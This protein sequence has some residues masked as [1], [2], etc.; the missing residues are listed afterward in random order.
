MSDL[1]NQARDHA[2]GEQYL[3]S[4]KNGTTMSPDS[5]GGK[6]LLASYKRWQ[7][8]ETEK[9]SDV[10]SLAALQVSLENIEGMLAT[11]V[12]ELAKARTSA[13]VTAPAITE[14]KAQILASKAMRAALVAGTP[15]GTTLTEG[16]QVYKQAGGKLTPAAWRRDVWQR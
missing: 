11:T 8:G 14:E 12:K 4:V 7:Q 3:A 13:A 16:F 5:P 10:K 6:S 9:A 2:R 15:V 1:V